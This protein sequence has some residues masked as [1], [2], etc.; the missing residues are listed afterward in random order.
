MKGAESKL[1]WLIVGILGFLIVLLYFVFS[2][3]VSSAGAIPLPGAENFGDLPDPEGEGLQQAYNLIF[4]LARNFRW[5]IG[6]VAILFIV[7]AGIK[8]GIQGQNEEVATS[9]K[10]NLYWGIVG[11]VI[12]MVAGPLSEIL[13]MQDGGILSDEYEIYYRAKLFDK[14]VH[15]II[16]F[17]KYII[18]SVAVLFIIR[19]G[20]KLVLAGDSDEVLTNEKKNLMGGIFGLVVIML[21]DT[22]V[23]QVLFKVDA[24]DSGFT[25]GGQEAVVTFDAG[26]GIQEIVGITNFIV[27]WAA[28]FAVLALVIGGFMYLTAFGDEEQTGKAKKIIFNSMIAL[29]IIYGA[30]AIV[31]TVISG[32]F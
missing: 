16:T 25:P 15:I 14:Q 17:V 22:I 18:G 3:E 24:P 2:T 29:V 11:L 21:A 20:A 10:K 9:Q 26:R 7:I 19:S 12:I 4:G 23:N 31:S 27:T 5:I 1:K 32:T 8:L 28:P 30:F 13:D 6:S